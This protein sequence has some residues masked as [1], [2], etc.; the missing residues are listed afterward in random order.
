MF[1]SPGF[2][3]SERNED[4]SHARAH[5]SQ[6]DPWCPRT[7][8]LA[9]VLAN[10]SPKLVLKTKRR[11]E[12]R[13]ERE[14]IKRR[15]GGERRK[16][17]A[18]PANSLPSWSECSACQKSSALR[19]SATRGPGSF[20]FFFARFS[21]VGEA[22]LLSP[23]P[24]SVTNCMLKL[25]KSRKMDEFANSEPDLAFQSRYRPLVQLGSSLGQ[26]PGSYIFLTLRG[27]FAVTDI[28]NQHQAGV[29]WC[30]CVCRM[31]DG[32][33]ML[34]HPSLPLPRAPRAQ[35]VCGS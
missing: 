32:R 34:H 11:E 3:A 12:E 30:L 20:S 19:L 1:A 27:N 14:K 23:Q 17:E 8:R 26:W 18:A 15:K 4:A 6:V 5:S 10:S 33:Y 29:P 28:G 31:Q 13:Q 9:V 21:Y 7:V 2:E 25:L 22:F 16:R 35:A 24:A